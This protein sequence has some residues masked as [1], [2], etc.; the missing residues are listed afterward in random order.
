MYILHFALQ[1][2][3]GAF[4]RPDDGRSENARVHVARVSSVGEV[5]RPKHDADADGVC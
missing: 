3:E 4:S 1:T 2:P 5:V